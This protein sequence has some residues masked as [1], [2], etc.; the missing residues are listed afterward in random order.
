MLELIDL[1]NIDE[2][3]RIKVIDLAHKDKVKILCA[4]NEMKKGNFKCLSGKSD[5][6]RLAAVIEFAV[7][8]KEK[9]KELNIDEKIFLDTM[10]DVRIWCENNL[11]KGLKNYNW[12][13]NHLNCQLFKLGRLQFQMFK[14][15]NPTLLYN[16]LPFNYG[17]NLIYVHI[18]QGEKLIYADCISSLKQAISFFSEYFPEFEYRY[19]F[20]ES[21]L[22]FEDNWIFMNPSSN[23]LQFS[24]I[25]EIA[26]SVKEDSQAI[27][28]IFGKRRLNKKN[29]PEDTSL[30]KNAK[31]F[32][33]NGGKLGIGIGVIDKETLQD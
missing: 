32:M 28:R 2:S 3:L 4:V 13:K 25:F 9:Y 11:N 6:F 7:V 29:Y 18:P 33:L 1:F 31:A 5:L 8:T 17:D 19:L 15:K 22:L 24:S 23:I 26:Y 12:I 10:D 20:C 30:Q 27:E 14:C 16:R 21:W